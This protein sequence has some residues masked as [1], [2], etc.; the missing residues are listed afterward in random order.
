MF[1]TQQ[2]QIYLT[3]QLLSPKLLSKS[4]KLRLPN[5]IELILKCD[6]QRASIDHTT[7]H[8]L[9]QN[10]SNHLTSY[11]LVKRG[12][13]ITYNRKHGCHDSCTLYKD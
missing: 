7:P 2:V 8:R 10:Y 9:D 12:S 11:H 13:Q 6:P 5:C 1:G 3:L 4:C